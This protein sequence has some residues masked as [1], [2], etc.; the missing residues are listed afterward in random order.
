MIELSEHLDHVVL[1]SGDGDFHRLVKFIQRRGIRVTVISTIQTSPSMVA[2]DLRRQADQFIDLVDL[3]K[4][5]EAETGIEADEGMDDELLD[6]DDAD[7]MYSDPQ[8]I[9]QVTA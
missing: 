5:I 7:L 6:D 3:V 4:L 2:D 9:S 8:D 1:F